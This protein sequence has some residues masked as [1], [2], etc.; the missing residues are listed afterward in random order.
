M[1]MSFANYQITELWRNFMP[2][3]NEIISKLSDELFSLA[4]Y[5]PGFFDHFSPAAEFERWAAVEVTD[6]SQVP[7]CMETLD[8]HGGL[9]AVFHYKG[10]SSDNKIWQYIYQTW[11]PASA[12]ILDDRPHFEV[13]GEKYRNNDPGSEEDIW[14]P[15]REKQVRT[16]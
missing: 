16:S 1:T 4:V 5:K 3:R 12:Y 13:L 8:L 15:V 14:I 2:R 9:Y 6:Y 10:L 7:E 11:L